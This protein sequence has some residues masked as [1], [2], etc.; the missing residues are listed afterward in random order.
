MAGLEKNWAGN[1]TFAATGVHLPTTVD[2]LQAIVSRAPRIRVVGSRHSFNAIA[3]S[4]ELVSLEAFKAP[5]EIDVENLSVTVGGGTR[6]SDLARE[7]DNAGFALQTMASLPHISVA[8]AVATATHGSGDRVGNLASSVRAQEVVTSSGDLLS[9]SRGD[10]DFD[11]MVV[12]LGAT[13]VVTRLSLDI[14]P[15]YQMTQQVFEHLPWETVFGEFDAIMASADSVSLFTDYGVDC[16][17][18]WQKWRFDK[19]DPRRPLEESFGARAAPVQRNPVPSLRPANDFTAQLGEPGT[20]AERLPHFRGDAILASE[21]QL[22][23][24]YMIPREHAVSALQTIFKLAPDFREHLW[25]SEIRSVAA[26]ELWMS[27]AYRTDVVGIHFTWKYE[28]EAVDRALHQIESALQPFSPRPHW[29]KLFHAPAAE[30][31]RRYER[32][33]DFM[34]LVNR[35]DP[36]GAFRNHF[37]ERHLLGEN[38]AG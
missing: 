34:E 20:W 38:A 31:Q 13:G 23:S 12:G 8:G 24:E 37:L 4:A 7:L 16:G 11:G 14:E 32:F 18:L 3:D 2:Q 35:V 28:I 17:Q 29:G 26:D 30:I 27:T 19:T 6:Y 21:S 36:R 25:I 5:M 9:L 22:Q 33:E 1:V 15:T 10:T